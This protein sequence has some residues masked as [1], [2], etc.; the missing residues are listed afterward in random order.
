VCLCLETG[1]HRGEEQGDDPHG[2][3]PPKQAL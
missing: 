1:E 3:E 2:L